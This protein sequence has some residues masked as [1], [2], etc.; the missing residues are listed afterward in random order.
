MASSKANEESS[1]GPGR[2]PDE[3]NGPNG[4]A[5]SAYGHALWKA[6]IG[7]ADKTSNGGNGDGVV[8]LAEVIKYVVADTQREGGHTPIYTGSYDP[9]LKIA[10]TPT[11]AEARRMLEGSVDAESRLQQLVDDQVLAN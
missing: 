1:T 4:S 10:K 9:Q 11:Y 2:D 8:T 6:L 3:P 5:G 7:Y